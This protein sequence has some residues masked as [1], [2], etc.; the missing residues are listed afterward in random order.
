[1]L[2]LSCVMYNYLG[3]GSCV[4]YDYLGIWSCV[5]YYYLGIGNI[6]YLLDVFGF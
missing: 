2:M 6:I 1:M 5:N 3:I 4:M